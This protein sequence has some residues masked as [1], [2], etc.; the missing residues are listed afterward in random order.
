MTVIGVPTAT[1]RSPQGVSITIA[2]QESHFTVHTWPEHGVAI[3]DIFNCGSIELKKH[4]NLIAETFGT[5]IKDTDSA[6]WSLIRF[7]RI[8]KARVV[9]HQLLR[10]LLITAF[11]RRTKKHSS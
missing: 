8:L 7:V 6:K 1:T 3:V 10:Y 5:D 4:L 11:W 9:L 2:L